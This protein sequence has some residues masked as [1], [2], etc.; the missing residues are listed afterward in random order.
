MN[1]NNKHS[2]NCFFFQTQPVTARTLETLIRLS[3]AHAKA[4]LSKKVTID[5]AHAAIELVQFAYFKE[6]LKKQKKTKPVN[7]DSDEEEEVVSSKKSTKRTRRAASQTP[8]DPN[9]VYAY[10]E[11]EED[12]T[13][14][15][16]KRTRVTR[17]KTPEE[18]VIEEESAM[19][20][21]TP[22]EPEPVTV[23]AEKLV[24]FKKYF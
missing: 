16:L 12:D 4:R 21:E 20:T 24:F 19:E 15:Q 2:K 13:Q 7:N 23:S 6:V 10:T 14:P 5:D 8:E 11:E 18:T 9:D 22:V 17:D 3:T 1:E